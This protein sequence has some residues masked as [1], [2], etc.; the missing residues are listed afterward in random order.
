MHEFSIASMIVD[1]LVDL[2]KKQNAK[3][4]LEVHLQIGQLRALSAEQV[5]FSYGI[6]VKRTILDGS[7]LLIEEVPA[8]VHCSACGYDSKLELKDEMSY[9]FALPSMVCPQCGMALSI[10]GGDECTISKV[11]LELPGTGKNGRNERE[12]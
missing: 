3:R 9:H 7:K 12:G 8:A 10:N 11:T 1:T 5:R 6:L 2:A 4:V